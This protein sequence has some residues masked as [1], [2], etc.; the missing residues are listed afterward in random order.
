MISAYPAARPAFSA[1]ARQRPV[2]PPALA[3]QQPADAAARA[4]PDA[5]RRVPVLAAGPAAL[6]AAADLA[7]ALPA[8]AGQAEVSARPLRAAALAAAA[9][10]AVLLAVAVDAAAP[11]AAVHPERRR[12]AAGPAAADVPALPAA[13][14]WAGLC[15]RQ[16]VLAVAVGERRVVAA[17]V[18]P[19]RAALRPAVL[20]RARAQLPEQPVSPQARRRLAQ[21]VAAD[22]PNVRVHPCP[23]AAAAASSLPALWWLSCAER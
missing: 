13:L 9:D 20:P 19:A 11:P 12:P 2:A 3:E 8:A 18:N 22:C 10:A 23:A 16:A 6:P 7:A 15:P 5:Q 4:V 1:P 17:A 14:H 21:R